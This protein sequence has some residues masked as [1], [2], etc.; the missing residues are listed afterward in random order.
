MLCFFSFH[1][2]HEWYQKDGDGVAEDKYNVEAAEVLVNEAQV[3]EVV[4]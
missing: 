2:F 1:N 4:F 3:N